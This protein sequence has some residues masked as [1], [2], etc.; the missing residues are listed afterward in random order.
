MS[1]H[2]NF[3]VLHD[4]AH[5]GVAAAWN[6][7]IYPFMLAQHFLHILA[8]MQEGTPAIRQ[9]T[10]PGCPDNQISQR[11][12]GPRGLAS[13]LEEYGVSAF[14]AQRGNLHQRV[15]PAFKNDAH[16][17]DGTAHTVQV[18]TWRKL[19]GIL[20]LPQRVRQQGQGPQPLRH[21]G[22]FGTGQFES[23]QQRR[24]QSF[25]RC[26]FHIGRIDGQQVVHMVFN[27]PRNRLQR[28]VARFQAGSRQR[29]RRFARAPR[30]A[31]NRVRHGI[32][33]FQSE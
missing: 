11:L 29:K 25:R 20:Y 32:L 23:A 13:A 16:H 1:Q 14:K 26:G 18:Q 8:G 12:I 6:N 3:A 28:L 17:S 9:A 10:L 33:P 2:R 27:F 4:V 22:A 19:L 15:R 5:K 21:A 7:Q 30:H 24:A 31:L